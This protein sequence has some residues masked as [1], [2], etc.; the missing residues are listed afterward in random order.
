L[1]AF[2]AAVLF[3]IALIMHAASISTDV[4]FSANS[5]VF[6]GLVCLALHEAGIGSG[7]RGRGRR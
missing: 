7:W 2:V 4:D 1:L 6:A 5:F 3:A